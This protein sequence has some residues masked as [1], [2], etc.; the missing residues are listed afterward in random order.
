M[1]QITKNVYAET[2]FRGSNNGFV[3]TSEGIV[4]IDTPQT[5][6][7]AVKWRDEIKKHGTVRYVINTEPHGDHFS[8]SYFFD[9]DV[10]GHEGTRQAILATSV[11]QFIQRT[12]QM[13]PESAVLMDGFRFRPPTI[14]FSQKLT[15]HLGEHTFILTN[16]PGH[17][18][19]QAA[20]FVPEEKVLFAS[21]NVVVNAFPFLHQSVINEW[22]NSLKKMQEFE[23]DF[24]MPGHGPVSD[25]KAF[26]AMNTTL[27]VWV[28]A[29]TNA[30]KQGLPVEEAQ[31]KISLLDRYPVPPER[32][33]MMKQT[34][35]ANIA[36]LYEQLK[37]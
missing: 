6:S 4:M 28:D 3:V 20:V 35:K 5:P 26:A 30:I 34:Q 13:A 15:L 32:A 1:Q 23:A 18:P 24:L 14:T 17:T 19:Y 10:V 7:E 9:G 29:V 31:E 11:E 8:G 12:K 2:G 16:F 25:R 36:R 33:A 37:K 27:Q 21:D 22:F